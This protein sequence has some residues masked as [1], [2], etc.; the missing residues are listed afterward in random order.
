MAIGI[1]ANVASLNAHTNT[2]KSDV[3]STASKT[4]QSAQK[5]AYSLNING[6]NINHTD[7]V[8]YSNGDVSID[9][10]KK[11]IAQKEQA[12]NV[13]FSDDSKNFDKAI[14]LGKDGS[15]SVSQANAN[16]TAVSNLVS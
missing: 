13:S 12:L 2:N 6:N 15:L 8:Q 3:R 4:D 1:A 7:N 5:A 16:N 9:E 14:L 10:L 11:D